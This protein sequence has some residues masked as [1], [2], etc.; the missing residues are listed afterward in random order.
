M[1]FLNLITKKVNHIQVTFQKLGC[2][3][4]LQSSNEVFLHTGNYNS[5]IELKLKISTNI[6]IWKTSTKKYIMPTKS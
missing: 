2:I 6:K 5:F 3:F 1:S 4:G